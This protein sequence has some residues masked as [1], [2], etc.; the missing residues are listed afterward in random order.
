M[1][2]VIA[3]KWLVKKDLD[4]TSPTHGTITFTFWLTN[5]VQKLATGRKLVKVRNVDEPLLLNKGEFVTRNKDDDF[6]A[7]DSQKTGPRL[8]VKDEQKYF[9]STL[10]EH[11]IST[12][13]TTK[14]TQFDGWLVT[15]LETFCFPVLRRASTTDPETKKSVDVQSLEELATLLT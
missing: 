10:Y 7:S 15:N 13:K 14:S 2:I 9:V 11:K 12:K 5:T 8:S 6:I 1:P 3:D 4:E